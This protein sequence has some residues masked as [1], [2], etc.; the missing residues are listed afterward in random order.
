[1]KRNFLLKKKKKKA[2]NEK[3]YSNCVGFFFHTNIMKLNFSNTYGK[4]NVATVCQPSYLSQVYRASLLS[5]NKMLYNA[6]DDT[7]A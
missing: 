7:F 2:R 6:E 1:M 4:D 5:A 3:E